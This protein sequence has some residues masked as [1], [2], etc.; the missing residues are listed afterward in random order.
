MHFNDS[1]NMKK[2][3]NIYKPFFKGVVKYFRF[4]QTERR[5]KEKKRNCTTKNF[6]FKKEKKRNILF[7]DAHLNND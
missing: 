7:K 6:L 4:K 3:N 5:K 1:T 2:T